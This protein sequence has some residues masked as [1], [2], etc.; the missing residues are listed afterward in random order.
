MNAP[1]SRS[2]SDVIRMTEKQAR[3]VHKL[4][5]KE[6]CN[7][8]DGMCVAL[9]CPCPQLITRSLSCKWFHHAV[10]PGNAPL[11][12]EIT[13]DSIKTKACAACGQSFV[14]TGSH[15]AYYPTC[16]VKI[17][18]KKTLRGSENSANTSRFKHP[19]STY[20]CAFQ[21]TKRTGVQ[22]HSYPRLCAFRA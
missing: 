13:G 16:A 15:S 8:M 6:C 4:V 11:Y 5:R 7:Y 17:R 1:A 20:S 12:V 22:F 10:L 9:D 18:R 2:P 19:R 21:D 3:E 14:P